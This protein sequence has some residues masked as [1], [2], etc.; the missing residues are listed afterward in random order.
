[1]W[2]WWLTWLQPLQ[3]IF[4]L[5][6]L[7]CSAGSL[8]KAKGLSGPTSVAGISMSDKWWG[9]ESAQADSRNC[10]ILSGCDIV[11]SLSYHYWW[12]HFTY[13]SRASLIYV[14]ELANSTTNEGNVCIARWTAET[15][16]QTALNPTPEVLPWWKVISH[17]F[18]VKSGREKQVWV[19]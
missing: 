9:L 4:H 7:E 8:S 12:T 1:M 17:F 19:K 11:C 3:Q 18:R 16:M 15:G 2:L 13:I 6:G 10:F 14:P 5:L